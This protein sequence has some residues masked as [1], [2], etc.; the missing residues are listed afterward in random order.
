MLTGVG[1]CRRRWAIGVAVVVATVVLLE[2]MGVLV[3]AGPVSARGIRSASAAGKPP[4]G[5]APKGKAHKGKGSAKGNGK[6]GGDD[7]CVKPSSGKQEQQ[8]IVSGSECAAEQVIV[9][10][11]PATRATFSAHGFRAGGAPPRCF[12]K[13]AVPYQFCILALQ[14]H[15]GQNPTVHKLKVYMGPNKHTA[16]EFTLKCKKPKITYR[17]TA[18]P[19]TVQV[20]GAT[21]L[22]FDVMTVYITPDGTKHVVPVPGLV[23]GFQTTFGTLSAKQVR[24]SAPAGRAVVTLTSARPGTARVTAFITGVTTAPPSKEN[25]AAPP[26]KITVWH[27]NVVFVPPPPPVLKK[28]HAVFTPAAF[29]TTY[30]ENASGQNLKYVWTVSIPADPGCAKGFQPNTPLAQQATWY[31]ADVSEGGPCNHG[32]YDAS[33]RGHPGTVTVTVTDA[34]WRCV[35]TYFG[36]QGDMGNLEGDGAAPQRCEQIP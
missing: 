33:G 20:P 36:T 29:S 27:A 9:F 25:P 5:K 16:G 1:T 2:G 8:I 30:T 11:D 4:K 23:V 15:Q 34:Y 13:V 24:T 28:I 31:H 35:A 21:T 19:G 10:V 17:L 12:Y 32:V 22:V 6:C 3:M 26:D 18:N 7:V 14:Y